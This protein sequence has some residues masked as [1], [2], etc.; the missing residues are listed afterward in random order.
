[1]ANGLYQLGMAS[2]AK[3][4]V[5][6]KASGGST[7]RALLID[8][9][10]YAVNLATD[11]FLSTVAGA[12]R[13]EGPVTMT[14]IDAAADGVCDGND[15]AFVAATGDPCEALLLYKFVTVDADSN[16]LVYIDTATG[17]PVTLNGGDVNVAWD[18]GANKI[19]KI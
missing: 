14:L 11:Q 18:N 10:D 19:V 12:A 2:W 1:M 13:E 9:A 7:I 17:L 4:D 16:L 15:V 3:G 8:A 6:W 5:A